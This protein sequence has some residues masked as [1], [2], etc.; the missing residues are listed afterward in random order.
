MKRNI[1]ILTL[2][3]I[4]SIN[5]FAKD[6]NMIH[7]FDDYKVLYNFNDNEL[8]VEWFVINDDVIGGIS[9]SKVLLT[10]DSCLQFSGTLSMENNGGFASIRT[11]KQS[12][13]LRGYK[14]IRIRVKGDGRLYQFRIRTDSNI[15]GIAYK[16]EF[17]TVDDEWQVIDLHFSSF[18]PTYRG[19]ILEDI[20]SI[21]GENIRQLG[22][23]I[24]DKSTTPFNLLLDKVIVFK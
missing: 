6:K 7:N 24:A 5:A 23:L 12:L 14:G 15:D 18:L 22:F 4:F 17:Q 8:A 9:K 19:R 3:M 20:E 11:G 21:V 2:V 16:H 1:Y 10:S 13:N